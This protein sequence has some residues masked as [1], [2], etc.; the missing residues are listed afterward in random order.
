MTARETIRTK[1]V[2]FEY[3]QSEWFFCFL[4]PIVTC[5]RLI[6]FRFYRCTMN[7][8]YFKVLFDFTRITSF[9]ISECLRNQSFILETAGTVTY[10]RTK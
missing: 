6:S 1:R 5:D 8:L 4:Y 3:S 2:Q 10:V 9:I 7:E